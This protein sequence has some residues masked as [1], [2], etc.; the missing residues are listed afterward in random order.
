M[1]AWLRNISTRR[2]PSVESLGLDPGFGHVGSGEVGD[3]PVSGDFEVVPSIEG[4]DDNDRIVEENEQLAITG[5]GPASPVT[6]YEGSPFASPASRFSPLLARPPVRLP[7]RRDRTR[8]SPS[9]NHEDETPV[10][11]SP[12]SPDLIPRPEAAQ[13]LADA[14]ATY[15]RP[16]QPD[17]ILHA[18][19][20]E[21]MQ[22]QDPE[23]Q[24]W[25][26]V[27]QAPD[28][29]M[30]MNA[31]RGYLGDED[32][33]VFDFLA[34]V[35]DVHGEH[36][37]VT[38]RRFAGR[39]L[40]DLA[41]YDD[42]GVQNL[43]SQAV[44]LRRMILDELDLPSIEPPEE[45]QS[46]WDEDL[47]ERRL[48]GFEDDD[49]YYDEDLTQQRSM[50]L[51]ED[52]VLSEM[53]GFHDDIS[54]F[55]WGRLYVRVL[56]HVEVFGARQAMNTFAR[57]IPEPVRQRL[58]H[59]GTAAVLQLG[60]MRTGEASLAALIADWVAARRREQLPDFMREEERNVTRRLGPTQEA[61]DTVSRRSRDRLQHRLE[62]S[63]TREARLRARLGDMRDERDV[64]RI[65]NE[66]LRADTLLGYECPICYEIYDN[67]IS[68]DECVRDH[69]M[70]LL[71]CQRRRYA[72]QRSAQQGSEEGAETPAASP[73]A[74]HQRPSPRARPSPDND[75]QSDDELARA[76]SP[77]RRRSR[78]AR[79]NSPN[80]LPGSRQGSRSRGSE[81]GSAQSSRKR[82]RSSSSS[83]GE[84]SATI[85]PGR[86]RRVVHHVAIT[87]ALLP[88][89]APPAAAATGGRL[90][91]SAWRA[92]KGR[93]VQGMK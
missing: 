53:S 82:R 27:Y 80:N 37:F 29:G 41:W 61:V 19:W 7:G 10:P 15:T 73:Q 84:V 92:G 33:D 93:L 11:E 18:P 43:E 39:Y 83:D 24:A 67:E 62:R 8:R 57:Y 3:D 78:G 48:T 66:D 2:S 16:P 74:N 79:P 34:R 36:E 12:I 65:A 13:R 35:A 52:A 68:K 63:R 40:D 55:S 31:I 56:R 86:R 71:E 85:P 38:R 87:M 59:L 23:Q 90:T 1:F 72:R 46:D 32:R 25:N 77:P 42:N 21:T 75:P 44:M 69:R 30:L 6:G 49:W 70:E 54:G 60:F 81:G 45:S 89:A 76:M 91:R 4:R 17:R 58:S 64:L 51:I 20:S 88:P 14:V 5:R 50:E 9:S 47:V 26:A 28:L 22:L